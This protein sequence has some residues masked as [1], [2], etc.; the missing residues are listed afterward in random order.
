M[1]DILNQLS[2]IK[3]VEPSKALFSKIE[4]R[5]EQSSTGTIS[6]FWARAAAAVMLC[7]VVSEFY[8][9]IDNS[10]NTSTDITLIAPSSDN[11]IS[12]E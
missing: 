10:K 11:I 6:L 4:K 3:K 12:Y 8:Y 7:L 5:I 1:E 9:I 2:A